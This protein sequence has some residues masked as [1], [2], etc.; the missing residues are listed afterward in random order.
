MPEAQDLSVEEILK[1]IKH[2]LSEEEKS[3]VSQEITEKSDDL[4][5]KTGDSRSQV[6]DVFVLTEDMRVKETPLFTQEDLK[7]QHHPQIVGS[8]L[9]SQ[10]Q[11]KVK[12]TLNNYF[13]QA[14]KAPVEGM[15]K[16]LEE[17]IAPLL[18]E[19]LDTHLPEIVEKIVE[20]EIKLLLQK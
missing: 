5:P 2:I 1:S 6:Q 17:S 14:S 20:R 13:Q 3:V 4:S 8:F 11:K 7:E 10:T 16:R 9:Q 18:K 19:W 15:E 12:E